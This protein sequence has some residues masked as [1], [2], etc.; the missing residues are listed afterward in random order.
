MKNKQKGA[1]LIVVLVFLVAITIIG[2][3]AIR[4][5]M[6]ALNIATNAQV[7]QLLTQNS[8]AVF[9]QTEK[10]SNLGLGLT[11]SG[12]FGYIKGDQDKD[13][14]LVFC[15]RG[16]QTSYFKLSNA[17][18][19]QWKEGADEPTNNDLGTEGYCDA[20]IQNTNWFTSGRRAVLTQVSVKF[21][22]QNTGGPFSNR[23]SGVDGQV[24]K[25]ED[26][27]PVK[28]FAVSI[29]PSLSSALRTDI[30]SCLRTKMNDVSIPKDTD[31]TTVADSNKQNVTTCL[32]DLGV[33]FTTQVS[34]Y[35]LAQESAS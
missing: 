31:S 9:F 20:T 26:S 1:T 35:V 13:K 12:M 2:T 5:S 10:P 30:N 27:R 33:P 6:V 21:P 34:E 24:S 3:I 29:M 23:V 22:T 18:I 17:S 28:V 19:M 11:A 15:Y 14:E 25:F 16:D 32:K 7:Q 8:D 4:Q